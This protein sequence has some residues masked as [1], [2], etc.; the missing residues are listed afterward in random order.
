MQV[1]GVPAQR[2]LG[3]GTAG[4]LPHDPRGPSGRRVQGPTRRNLHWPRSDT[5]FQRRLPRE[6]VH[7][8]RGPHSSPE[9]RT[10]VFVQKR[11]ESDG[12]GGRLDSL[13]VSAG[14]GH[15]PALGGW[16]RWEHLPSGPQTAGPGCMT[17]SPGPVRLPSHHG[18]ARSPGLRGPS[19]SASR[20]FK[21]HTREGLSLDTGHNPKTKQG[22]RGLKDWG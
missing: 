8:P 10:W 13:R 11:L 22:S 19:T 20:K 21:P 7:L 15:M 12:E 17:R 3:G 9:R 2:H 4:A 14:A 16:E 18:V 1:V 5:S 6:G